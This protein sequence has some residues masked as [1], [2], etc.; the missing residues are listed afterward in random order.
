[1]LG[2]QADAAHRVGDPLALRLG[3][4][5]GHQPQPLG[6]QRAHRHPRVEGRVGILEDHLHLG[7]DRLEGAALE[8]GDFRAA[9]AHATRGGVEQAHYQPPG[10]RLA[11][12]ALAHQ[13]EG[14]AGPQVEAHAVDRVDHPALAEQAAAEFEVLGEVL[15]PQEFVAHRSA[16]C[17]CSQQAAAWVEPRAKP[18]GR[19][20]SHGAKA[21]GQR[22]QNAQ[23]GGKSVRLGTSPPIS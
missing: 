15:H 2:A 12:A 20:R 3:V 4:E 22:G 17:R 6:D 10:G 18:G 19:S 5:V 8:R 21:S 9:E 14:L 11:A 23:P 13:A 16:S 1:M 7:A